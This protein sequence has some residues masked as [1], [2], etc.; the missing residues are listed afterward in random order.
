[1]R[2]SLFWRTFA[3]I[4]LLLVISLGAWYKLYRAFEQPPQA[5]RLAWELASTINLARTALMHVRGE[6]R[7]ALLDH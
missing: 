6:E 5:N 2:L 1:M 7:K 4:S 3:L